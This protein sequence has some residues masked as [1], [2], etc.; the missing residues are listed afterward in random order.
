MRKN[1]RKYSLG[2]LVSLITF[3]VYL[4]ALSNGFVNWDDGDYVY[5]NPYIRSLDLKSL[6]W[7]FFGF[8][9]GNWHPLTWISHAVD[10]TVWGLNPFGYHLLNNIL[11][12]VNTLL[13]FLLATRLV[14]IARG[15]SHGQAPFPD[16]NST[17]VAGA[18][19]GLLFGIHPLHVESVAWVAER[20]DVLCA[21]FFL[22]SVQSY[23]FSVTSQA[24]MTHKKKHYLF[25]FIFFALA[26]LS[27]PMAVTLPAVLLVID[28]YPLRRINS[29]R[30]LLKS[31]FVKAPFFGLSLFSS[32][33]TILAQESGKAIAPFTFQPMTT[34]LTVAARAVVSYAS[35][36]LF[37]VDLLPFYPYPQDVSFFS[38][39][40]LPFILLVIACAA[41]C[42]AASRRQKLWLAAS[43]Y[44]IVTLLPVLGIIQV[45]GQSMADRYTYLPSIGP[46]IVVGLGAA[47]L[48]EKARGI[49]PHG[50]T[51][52]LVLSVPCTL[53][54]LLLSYTSVRQIGIWK[55]SVTLWSYLIEKEP[56]ATTPAYY[57]LGL[58]Y[59]REGLLEPA[60]ENFSRA[61][62][63]NP[64]FD[65]AYNNRGAALFLLGRLDEALDDFNRAI[66]L[67]PAN[68]EAYI[69]RGYVY[70]RKGERI[71]AAPDLESGCRLGNEQGCQALRDLPK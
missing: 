49:A 5:D 12:S 65:M 26:L 35:K 51:A 24:D 64:R 32:V 48:F 57:N 53:L 60:I 44:Y 63:I 70:L 31:L 9:A 55:N 42:I 52:V 71:L 2:G 19:A 67:N 37:P 11:H 41:A 17:L 46:F 1:L 15:Y 28:W 22:L 68:A 45:G 58:F 20:K 33:V 50:R 54:I 7:A 25:S 10:Y 47:W 39:E 16:E 40:Y 61:I 38:R 3:L 56:S 66:F 13:V 4:P 69:N 18:A 62:E 23:L 6:R 34:R 27:K 30:T 8:H 36:M 21:F 14:E 29:V 43:C 59:G